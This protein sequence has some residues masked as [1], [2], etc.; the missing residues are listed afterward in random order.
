MHKLR[1]N[2]DF[3]EFFVYFPSVAPHKEAHSKIEENKIKNNDR[4]S[5]FLSIAAHIDDCAFDAHC[6][7][8]LSVC[9]CMCVSLFYF[10][11]LFLKF[12]K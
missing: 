9:V 12:F 4:D 2:N 8:S 3:R 11:H 6:R 1:A 7:H 10:L 5:F